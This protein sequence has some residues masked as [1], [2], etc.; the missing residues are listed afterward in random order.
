MTR[1]RKAAN[2][3]YSLILMMVLL[4]WH[5]TAR[6]DHVMTIAGGNVAAGENISIEVLVDNSEPFVAFQLDI[7]LPDQLNYV[8]GSAVLTPERKVNHSLSVQIVGENT[9]RIISYSITNTPFAGNSGPVLEFQLTAGNYPGDYPLVP[10]NPIISGVDGDNILTDAVQGVVSIMAPSIDCSP[11]QLDFGETPLGYQ[12]VD[13]IM[14]VKNMGNLD[15]E[16]S[17]VDFDVPW[18]SLVG[19]EQF[20][21]APGEEQELTIRFSP[22]EQGHFI[23]SMIIHSNDPANPQK[24][25]TLE[26]IAFAVNELHCGSMLSF[27]GYKDTLHFSINNMEAFVAFQFDLTLPDPLT[28]VVGSATLSGRKTDHEVAVDMYDDNTLRV[29]AYSPSNQHFTGN[30]GEIL[31]LAFDV[32]GTGGS[33]PLGLHEVIISDAAGNNIVS[34][35]YSGGLEVA[36]PY[37]SGPVNIDFGEVSMLDTVSQKFTIENT[38]TDTLFIDD[39]QISNDVFFI[40]QATTYEVLTGQA[41]ELELFYHGPDVGPQEGQ[42][43][44]FSNFPAQNPFLVDLYAYSYVPNWMIAGDVSSYMQDT[45]FVD[46]MVENQEEFVAFEF[47]LTYPGDIMTFLDDEVFTHLTDRAPDHDLSVGQTNDDELL[48]FAYSLEGHAFSGNTGSV[49]RLGFVVD[50]PEQYASFPLV[51]S[52]AILS[53]NH[54]QNILYGTV[55][56]ELYIQR[57]IFYLT[58]VVD[59]VGGGQTHGGGEYLRNTEVLIQAVAE[60]HHHFLFWTDANGNEISDQESFY[61]VMPSYDV[62]FTA[63]F[64]PDVYTLTYTAG[65]HGSLVGDTEQMVEHGGD[66]TPVEAIPDEGYHF[67]QWSDGVTD[68]PRTDV[69][70]QGPLDV[71][72]HFEIN[73]YTLT[74]TAGDHGSLV[75]DTEQMVEH[76]GDGTPVEAIPD[77]GYHFTQW[78]DGVTDNPRTDVNVQGP[79]DVTAHFAMNTYT[80][81]FVVENQH[82]EAIA[83]AVVTLEQTENPPG[84]Y[85]FED[86]LPGEYTYLVVAENYFDASG[87]VQVVDQDITVTV[88]M[89]VDDTGIVSVHPPVIKTYPNPALN[90]LYVAFENCSDKPV[91]ISLI[92]IHGQQ[93]QSQTIAEKGHQEIL[94]NI[95]SLLPGL[96]LLRVAYDGTYLLEKVLVQ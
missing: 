58:L 9:L 87:E 51:L 33:Y 23:E 70:V 90:R 1:F 62:T 29:L 32:F 2:I 27:S 64:A 59:P 28:Y 8:D 85:V 56:G 84:D 37:L 34:A 60:D 43:Q 25:V 3:C 77:E 41:L 38:G 46:I 73:V 76:G 71:T 95:E 12:D 10:V 89:E 17:G 21:L 39:L 78:S 22:Q 4:G 14:V 54:V 20:T 36:A 74:Y 68:N 81:T 93:I 47:V 44:I 26:A 48:V 86:V 52:N 65:D 31:S 96:Y 57:S 15:L 53:D 83:N 49:V 67:T 45:I 88:I 80:I 35:Y 91:K 16:V 72:A 30:V 19:S 5:I 7:H 69:N 42:L 63:H 18:F 40:E 82:E 55:D 94:F 75:G 24:Q 13:M 61:Y 92:N 79:L 11:E 66:G 50:A 6:A